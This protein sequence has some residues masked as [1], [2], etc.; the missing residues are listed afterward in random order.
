MRRY[1]LPFAF[2]ITL[3]W[4]AG[5]NERD[6]KQLRISANPWVGFT[7][8][9]YAQQKG[10]LKD[11]DIKF[12]WVVGLEESIKLYKQGLSDGFVGTQYEYYSLKKREGIKPYFLF[13][14][15]SGADVILSNV[16]LNTLRHSERVDAYLEITGLN[17]DL[18]Q[19]FNSQYGLDCDKI[20]MHSSD[21]ESL[22]VMNPGE[23]PSLLIAYEPYATLIES[24]GF[25]RLA[26]TRE[27]TQMMVIDALWLR[28]NAAA[29]HREDIAT[30]TKALDRAIERLHADPMEYYATVK[31]HLKNQS[32][33]AFVSSLEGI[34]WINRSPSPAVM[35]FLDKEQIPTDA[36]AR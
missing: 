10:W 27:I 35:K 25:Q 6:H 8:I 29:E 34:K 2:A 32:Y 36:I 9:V 31:S 15:S 1:L 14:R 22:S 7:P 11:L 21:P 33:E 30:F 24:N 12:L 5:C 18:L 28:Q 19:A 26:S 3:L 4:F 16:S 17:K 13:D 23:K 20:I